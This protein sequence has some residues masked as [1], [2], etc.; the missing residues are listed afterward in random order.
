[1]VS[2]NN[3]TMRF[4]SQLLFEDI[5]LELDSGKR[6]GLIGANGAGKSTFMKILA[7]QLEPTS[8]N[9]GIAL[10]MIGQMKGYKVILTM[11]NTMSV[12]R[13]SLME[14]YGAEVK[15]TD[16]S[17]G[18]RGAIELAESI[19]EDI[20]AFM[21]SQFDN[22]INVKAHYN[23]TAVEIITDMPDID[24]FITGIGTGGTISGVGKA[25]KEYNNKV[26]IIGVE[27]QNSAVI[28]GKKAGAHKIQGIGAGF[29]PS[30]YD[31]SVVDD[32]MT[33]PDDETREYA[34]IIA[35]KEG[36][37]LG[38]SSAANILCAIKLAKKLGA[39][40]KILT[41]SAD[42]GYKYISEGIY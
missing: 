42:N 3:I 41:I 19:C 12:E 14:G 20:G 9:T 7:G 10:A 31:K 37:M 29:I 35:K 2:I 5:N 6:Y 11:P 34:S 33:V 27:P 38:I 8:G 24:V 22:I 36:L 23:T 40:K 18:M 26:K 28:S 21:P 4:G 16:G 39:D 13:I 15:L 30:I 1:M 25:L 17:K 32:I